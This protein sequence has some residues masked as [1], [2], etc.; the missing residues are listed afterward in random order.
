MLAGEALAIAV[1]ELEKVEC[2]MIIIKTTIYMK[3]IYV[4]P[5][6]HHYHHDQDGRA[7]TSIN[8]NRPPGI[9][10]S[11]AKRFQEQVSLSVASS[12]LKVLFVCL[13]FNSIDC[14]IVG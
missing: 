4:D 13:L 3:I 5:H 14:L 9:P 8:C 11:L 6:L 7:T 12:P 2:M 1:G 10:S